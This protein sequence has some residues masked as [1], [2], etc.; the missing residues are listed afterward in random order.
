M[1]NFLWLGVALGFI[2]S[3]LASADD[4]VGQGVI[5]ALKKQGG[6]NVVIA[7]VEPPSMGVPQ[8]DLPT[9]RSEISSLQSQV[10]SALSPS[11]YRERHRYET[12][13]SL[14]IWV[15]KTGLAKLVAHP[16]VV[17]IDLDVGGI[18]A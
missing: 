8:I 7:L 12:V 10:L 15:S 17:R 18:G 1:R 3:G 11:D 13:P 9:L 6:A 16:K 4:K 2:S 14:A 5:E